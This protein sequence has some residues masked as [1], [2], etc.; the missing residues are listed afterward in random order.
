MRD[1]SRW[2]AR[3]DDASLH[4]AVRR[5]SRIDESLQELGRPT[6]SFAGQGG[7][8]PFVKGR[9]LA[10]FVDEHAID[11]IH[12]HWKDDL[13]LVA[14]AKKMAKRPVRLVHTRQ[15]SLPGRKMDPYHRYVYGSLDSF[16]AITRTIAA[17]AA[18]NLP[19][20]K[21]K[22]VQIY[23][24]VEIPHTDPESAD[25]LRR[26]L[27]LEG[28]FVVGVVGR[29]TEPK[30]QHLLIEA[31]DQL[32]SQG[33][34]VHGLIVGEAFEEP[35]VERL[36]TM[37]REKELSDQVQFMAFQAKPYAIMRCL[38][39]LALTTKSETFG[40]VLVEAMQCGLAVIGSNAGG[41]P[42][43][44]DD[45][46]TGFLFEPWNAASLA[47]SIRQL[48]EHPDVRHRFAAAGK[49]KA[50]TAFDAGQQ[51]EK[52]YAALRRQG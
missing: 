27:S 42:E 39:V 14:L 12:V 29:V 51:N 4:L 32:R 21:E 48:Y 43:I 16:I 22:I 13:P 47:S 17:Q 31:I 37:V 52:F 46:Q 35:Y 19:I 7:A 15:M 34:Q 24:G 20:N 40:L 8:L 50:R 5:D 2:L 49:V 28:K 1:F 45:G 18:N 6:I 10:R 11:T 25:R 33:I 9:R 36:N 26:E 30:G 38:D 41:V 3:R 44:I 23:Y